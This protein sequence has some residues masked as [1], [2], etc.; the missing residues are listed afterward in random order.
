ML[1]NICLYNVMKLSYFVCVCVCVCVKS[2][3]SCWHGLHFI[4]ITWSI[5]LKVNLYGPDL[6]SLWK[7]LKLMISKDNLQFLFFSLFL[8]SCLSVSFKPLSVFAD[9]DVFSITM[10]DDGCQLREAAS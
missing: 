9:A 1:P 10:S 3:Y 2:M 4:R 6:F 5:F 8:S 7:K